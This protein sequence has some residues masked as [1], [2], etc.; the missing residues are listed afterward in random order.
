MVRYH[1]M[2]RNAR[3]SYGK[4]ELCITQTCIIYTLSQTPMVKM[5]KTTMQDVAASR[6]GESRSN[7][8]KDYIARERTLVSNVM[9]RV[10]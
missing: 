1:F 3:A 2:S 6:T 8:K 5:R 7:V 9:E 4:L 10:K